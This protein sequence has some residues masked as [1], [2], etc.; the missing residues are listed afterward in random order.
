MKELDRMLEE[1]SVRELLDSQIAELAKSSAEMK[2]CAA[3]LNKAQRRVGF[4][5]LLVNHLKN[6]L[7]R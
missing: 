6:R 5:L 2:T 3:D 7:E 4:A 1:K